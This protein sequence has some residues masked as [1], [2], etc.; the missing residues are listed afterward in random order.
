MHGMMTIQCRSIARVPYYTDD[1]D[2]HSLSQ[3]ACLYHGGL[4]GFCSCC[5]LHVNRSF[6]HMG[7]CTCLCREI[8]ATDIVPL[9]R[10]VSKHSLMVA[11]RFLRCMTSSLRK[12]HAGG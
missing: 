1:Y 3:E 9:G 10:K 6:P 11:F 12:R 8:D 4:R 2:A 7:S 5:S